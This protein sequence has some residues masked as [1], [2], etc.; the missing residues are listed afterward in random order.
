MKALALSLAFLAGGA[1]A[2]TLTL[3]AYLGQ[4]RKDNPQLRAL[5]AQDVA[6]SLAAREPETAYSPQLKAQAQVLNDQLEP[7][8]AAFSPEQTKSSGLDVGLSKLFSTGTYVGVNYQND[9]TE[10]IFP[11]TGFIGPL[12]ATTG[13]QWGVTLS[14]SLW[15]N[16]NASEVKASIL[17]AKAGADSSRAASRYGAQAVLFQARSAYVQL[18][19]VRQ[20]LSLQEESLT[21]NAKIL[22]WTQQKQADNLADKVDVLQVEAAVRL[23]ALGL[24]SSR[25]AEAEASARFNALRGLDPAAPAGDLEPLSLPAALPAPSGDRAD[26]EAAR[27]A[28]KSSDAMVETVVQRFT[29]DISVF[30]QLGANERDTDG[31]KAFGDLS[32]NKHPQSLVGIKLTANLDRALLQDVLRGAEQVKGAG[33]AQIDD[34]KL[35]LAQDWK[36]LQEQWQGLQSRLTLAQELEKLQ[37]EKAEREKV[38]YRDGRTTNFQ[39]LRFEDDYSLARIQILQLL[40]NARVLEAQARF[41]NG[42]DQPW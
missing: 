3:D 7:A 36:Q 6:L 37:G 32:N 19:T 16:F 40:A 24:A 23:V 1:H 17:Q 9:T 11:A 29:P 28:L 26:I 22:E 25:Q 5:K 12:P 14:Q 18:E 41:Y 38:R 21:R 13:H 30:A 20:V 15:R 10:L 2:D 31:G 34:K 8:L 4:V 35:G 42:D 39:V 27:Q 33:Q